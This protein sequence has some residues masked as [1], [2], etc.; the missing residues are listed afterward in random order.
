MK[1]SIFFPA[2]FALLFANIFV[3][4]CRKDNAVPPA[5]ANEESAA[6]DRGPCGSMTIVNGVGLRF[7]GPA[8]L[9]TGPCTLCGA[10]ASGL[11]VAASPT[12]VGVGGA[13]TKFTVTNPTLA[14]INVFFNFN[15]VSGGGPFTILPGATVV[16]DIIVDPNGCCNAVVSTC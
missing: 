7:C 8:G 9:G 2:L 6:A 14:N 15:C 12:I 13:G 5:P 4:S 10:L 16:F 11:S 3:Y 1:K